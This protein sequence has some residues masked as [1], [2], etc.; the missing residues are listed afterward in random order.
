MLFD[1]SQSSNFNNKLP[2]LCKLDTSF[3][4][5]FL[6]LYL[7]SWEARDWDQAQTSAMNS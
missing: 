6:F 7:D 5:K 4:S 1:R 2:L 3:D